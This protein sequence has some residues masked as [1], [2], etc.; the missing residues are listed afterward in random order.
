VLLPSPV[1]H[2]G[3]FATRNTSFIFASCCWW[4]SLAVDGG[5]GHLGD[6]WPEMRRPP[7]GRPQRCCTAWRVTPS[8]AAIS[9]QEYRAC[10]SPV[11]AWVIASS[12]LTTSLVCRLGR[13]RPPLP[14][15][16]RGRVWTRRTNE[17]YSS[18]STGRRRRFGVNLALTLDRPARLPAPDGWS[19]VT[20]L[21]CLLL[22]PRPR[23]GG[24]AWGFHPIGA[25]VVEPGVEV[26]LRL[27]DALDW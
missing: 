15:A 20:G 4:R 17:A 27:L 18:F 26:K 6:T 16:G 7:Y 25:E 22:P 10:R 12:S 8:R 3:E 21:I 13:Q 9:A 23:E 2:T 11:T 24:T 5:S 19:A 1:P 14:L